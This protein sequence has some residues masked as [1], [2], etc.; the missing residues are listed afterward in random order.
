MISRAAHYGGYQ[1]YGQKPITTLKPGQTALEREY[2]GAVGSG[3]EEGYLSTYNRWNS[4]Y[5][6]KVA[7]TVGPEDYAQRSRRPFDNAGKTIVQD[8]KKVLTSHWNTVYQNEFD[9]KDHS[10][11]T[12]RPEWS[13]HQKPHQV[14]M[15]PEFYRS[16]YA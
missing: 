8:D 12:K 11:R 1:S 15:P 14:R 10:G 3:N 2:Y 16:K 6:S 4:V 7:A 13:Y 9:E 5:S